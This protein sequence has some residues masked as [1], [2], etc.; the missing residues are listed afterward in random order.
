MSADWADC[1]GNGRLGNVR[2]TRATPVRDARDRFGRPRKLGM[3]R[4]R[5]ARKTELEPNKQQVPGGGSYRAAGG[6][7]VADQTRSCRRE[8]DRFFAHSSQTPW[9][10][11]R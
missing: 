10:M 9:M 7:R 1:M 4:R 2:W 8:T 5:L 6:D 11:N 3:V